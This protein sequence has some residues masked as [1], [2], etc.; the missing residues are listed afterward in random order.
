MPE[1]RTTPSSTHN[2]NNYELGRKGLPLTNIDRDVEPEAGP[3]NCNYYASTV[4]MVGL[5][6]LHPL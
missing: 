5:Q 2:P 6:G 3:W 1:R 4:P